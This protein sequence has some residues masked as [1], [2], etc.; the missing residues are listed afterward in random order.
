MILSVLFLLMSVCVKLVSF[1]NWE[2]T[3]LTGIENLFLGDLGL[4]SI[5]LFGI[6]SLCSW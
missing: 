2:V 4:E 3:L 6:P 5:L 1:W